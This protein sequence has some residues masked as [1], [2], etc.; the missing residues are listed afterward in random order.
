M[1]DRINERI[2]RR[3]RLYREKIGMTQAELA[4]AA[5]YKSTGT[6][7]LIERGLCGVEVSKLRK[8]ARV[9]EV[10]LGA[11][12]AFE[13]FSDRKLAALLMFEKMLSKP[14]PKH[15]NAILKLLKNEA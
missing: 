7:S 12:I 13:E 6:I 15:L 3:I 8:I 9:L 14:K 5:G 2:G 11:L 1:R 10:D 4:K